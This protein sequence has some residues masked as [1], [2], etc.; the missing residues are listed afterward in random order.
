MQPR[1]IT[2]LTGPHERSAVPVRTRQV[3]TRARPAYVAAACGQAGNRSRSRAAAGFGGCLFHAPPTT[4]RPRSTPDN[5]LRL[6]AAPD[7]PL[8]SALLARRS[9]G[10]P[11]SPSP[12]TVSMHPLLN[13]GR[14]SAAATDAPNPH[15]AVSQPH[16][17][18]RAETVSDRSHS[19]GSSSPPSPAPGL[20]VP[21]RWCT[22]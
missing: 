21:A 16:R 22:L 19:I 15:T 9:V 5:D 10:V 13:T 2:R 17:R 14:E 7:E 8:R 12:S 1:D 18:I 11:A 6:R 20:S 3:R 4:P